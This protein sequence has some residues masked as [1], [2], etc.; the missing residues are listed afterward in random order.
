MI[1]SIKRLSTALW[2]ANNIMQGIVV[3]PLEKRLLHDQHVALLPAVV[4][5]IPGSAFRKSS[6]LELH[7]VS[8]L[9]NLSHS[10]DIE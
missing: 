1:R 9:S 8:S 7:A 6:Y 4:A 3:S 5:S 2:I 10:R